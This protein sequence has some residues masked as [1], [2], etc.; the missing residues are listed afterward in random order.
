[1]DDHFRV[2]VQ[3]TRQTGRLIAN[4]VN[5]LDMRE[6]VRLNSPC[7]LRDMIAH[8]G[9]ATHVPQH[10]DSDSALS[11]ILVTATPSPSVP[12]LQPLVHTEYEPE[13]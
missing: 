4:E 11:H 5:G 13:K 6:L 12:I 10:D 9:R 7:Y 2:T 8:T 3:R 1:M